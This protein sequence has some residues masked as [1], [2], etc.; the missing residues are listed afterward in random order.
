MSALIF[1]ATSGETY[2]VNF[3][4]SAVMRLDRLTR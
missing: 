2:E 1:E 3:M 4:V